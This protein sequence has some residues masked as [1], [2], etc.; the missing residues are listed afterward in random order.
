M[1]LPTV[2]LKIRDR[3]ELYAI[4]WELLSNVSSRSDLILLGR[5][6]E[7]LAKHMPEAFVWNNRSL[8]T[9]EESNKE[10]AAF[11]DAVKN[12]NKDARIPYVLKLDGTSRG[13]GVHLI[14]ND[15]MNLPRYN[16][17]CCVAQKYIDNP[18][19]LSCPKNPSIG[20]KWDFRMYVLVVVDG[21]D[22]TQ[23]SA[24]R[25]AD[26]FARRCR[27]VYDDNMSDRTAHI[28]NT[29]VNNKGGDASFRKYAQEMRKVVEKL[30]FEEAMLMP[31]PLYE[32][33]DY[34]FLP[35][36]ELETG[37]DGSIPI[38]MMLNQAYELLGSNY[39]QE[40]INNAKTAIDEMFKDV[41]EAAMSPIMQP[42]ASNPL[43]Y[44]KHMLVLGMDVLLD[45]TLKPHLLEINRYPDMSC[46]SMD[47]LKVKKQLLHDVVGQVFPSAPMEVL[48]EKPISTAARDDLLR[49]LNP[50]LE[51]GQQQTNASPQ[52]Y[53]TDRWTKLL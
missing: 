50:A 20:F 4:P 24:Y 11:W 38:T 8:Q 44:K 19:L 18:C 49:G 14:T 15:E 35:E 9:E 46:Y 21:E 10:R 32:E 13:R 26:A 31:T 1:E 42:Q 53:K 40:E 41:L 27:D 37:K 29:A 25:Y 34:D 36:P 45:D 39:S 7:K 52:V 17:T 5:K 43:S 23:Y 51:T 47:Q 2:Y 48:F 33:E 16:R 3:L 30:S 12:L 6:H 28:T 22:P